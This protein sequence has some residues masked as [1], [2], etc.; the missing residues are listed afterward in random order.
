MYAVNDKDPMTLIL[1]SRLQQMQVLQVRL[2]QAIT[3]A[4]LRERCKSQCQG[5]V[6][7]RCTLINITDAAEE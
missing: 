6:S 3:G 5:A 2:P 1:V 7:D 4:H